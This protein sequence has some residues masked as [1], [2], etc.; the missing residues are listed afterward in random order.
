[1]HCS[2]CGKD[3]PF[4]GKVCPWCH[5]NK[6]KDQIVTVLGMFCGAIGLFLGAVIG[7]VGWAIGGTIIGM[8]LGIVLGTMAHAKMLHKIKILNQNK[9]G[10]KKY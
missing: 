5:H 1:M 8:F 3:I 9:D 4:T 7:G 10:R 6:E 2:N